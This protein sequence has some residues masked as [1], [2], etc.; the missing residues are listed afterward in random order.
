MILPLLDPGKGR[1]D[2]LQ[3]VIVEKAKGEQVCEMRAHLVG[4]QQ[5][6]RALLL[7]KLQAHAR[8]HGVVQFAPLHA[9]ED[10]VGQWGQRRSS[11]ENKV[12]SRRQWKGQCA[13]LFVTHVYL[14]RNLL[15]VAM[16]TRSLSF[17]SMMLFKR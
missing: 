5:Q 11:K 10:V 6:E 9:G 2:A 7:D 17:R 12:R 8:N 4:H 3:V 14:R 15:H 16:T 1:H 13:R